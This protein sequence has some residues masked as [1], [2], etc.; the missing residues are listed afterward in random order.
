MASVCSLF[1]DSPDD[2]WYDI[3]ADSCSPPTGE[4]LK[5]M[6]EASPSPFTELLPSPPND[7]SVMDLSP[8]MVA[9]SAA[10]LVINAAISI[11]LDL[12]MHLQLLVASVR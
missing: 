1:F 8:L 10:V 3:R 4:G 5:N 9:M 12:G 6:S 11:K 2:K 7:G